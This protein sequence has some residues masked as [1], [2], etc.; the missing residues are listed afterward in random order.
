MQDLHVNHQQQQQ[1]QQQQPQQPQQQHPEEP[2]R[3]VLQSW[4]EEVTPSISIGNLLPDITK[5]EL[6]HIFRPFPGF[7]VRF[8]RQKRKE[9]K[10][11]LSSDGG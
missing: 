8:E 3:R 11:Q 10:G 5:R 6:A 4:Q 2:G 1:Q 9:K 7:L